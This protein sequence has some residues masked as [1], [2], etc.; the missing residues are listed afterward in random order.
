MKQDKNFANFMVN[1][2]KK[3]EIDGVTFEQSGDEAL[4]MLTSKYRV[5]DKNGCAIQEKDALKSMLT[6]ALALNK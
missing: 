4:H 5:V 6:L 3:M 2:F 1:I